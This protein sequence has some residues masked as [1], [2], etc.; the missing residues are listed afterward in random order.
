VV[1]PPRDRVPSGNAQVLGRLLPIGPRVPR[2]SFRGSRLT[3]WALAFAL[4]TVLGAS[5]TALAIEIEPSALGPPTELSCSPNTPDL[6]LGLQLNFIGGDCIPG[7]PFTPGNLVGFA[8]PFDNTVASGQLTG[9]RIFFLNLQVNTFNL[10]VWNDAG[11][12]PNDACGSERLKIIGAPIQGDSPYTDSTFDPPLAW[13]QG[14]RLW[15]GAVYLQTNIPPLWALGRIAGPS[16]TGRAFANFTGDHRDWFDLD[17]FNF[18][19][20]F[21]VHA[22]LDPNRP[23]VA[24]AGGPYC[25]P[26]LAPIAFNGSASSDPDGDPLTY[27]WDFGDGGTATGPTPSHTYASGGLYSVILSVSDSLATVADTTTALVGPL[28]IHV[29]EDASLN[30]ALAMAADCPIDSIL[31]GPGTYPGPI[32]I[33]STNAVILATGG[34]AITKLELAGGSAPVVSILSG[35]PHLVGFTIT[36]PAVGVRLAT[37]STLDGCRVMSCGGTGVLIDCPAG[38]VVTSCVIGG[39]GLANPT[40]GGIVVRGTHQIN[41]STIHGNGHFAISAAPWDEDLAQSTITRSILTGSPAGPGIACNPDASP[42]ISCS[43]VWGNNNG[44]TLCGVDGGNNFTANPLFCDPVLLDLA[45]RQGSPCLDHQGCGRIGALGQACGPALSRIE[46][47]VIG[48]SGP[49]A[50]LQVRALH[51]LAG[52]PVASGLTAADGRYSIPTLGA[53]AYRVE[54]VTDGTQWVGEYYP[55]LVSYLPSNLALA[56]PVAVDGVNPVTGIDFMLALGG[57]FSGKV[58]DQITHAPLAGVPVNGFIF[59]GEI[60]RPVT[61]TQSGSYLS[62]ALLPGLYGALVPETPGYF[63]EVYWERQVPAEGDTIHIFTGQTQLNISFTLLTGGTGVEE[64]AAAPR[65][66]LVLDPPVPNP[67]NPHTEIGFTLEHDATLVT[68]DVYD[69]QGR[70]VRVLHSGPLAQGAHRITWDGR[71]A[72][73]TPVATGVYLVRLQAG[74]EERVRQAVLIR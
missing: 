58:T 19:Q 74:G 71:N 16:Q 12:I 57:T 25:G 38:A 29:P 9:V 50:G 52:T 49:L 23:P 24:Q 66:G 10:Y 18:G 37:P 11:G 56:T 44:N 34:P 1:V 27:H 33:S 21:G 31:V 14:Q 17:D 70:R 32:A 69:V 73:G 60:L 63:G 39:N 5:T 68:L 51:P 20:C 47:Q 53:G 36:G 15:I 43:D 62:P 4:F 35:S 42:T 45:L 67:F 13:A 22:E 3:G 61:T 6:K 46:G 30:T 54:V 48:T 28:T 65:P 26:P 40:A 64:P 2:S 59:G 72:A 8:I 41:L 7:A 55:N